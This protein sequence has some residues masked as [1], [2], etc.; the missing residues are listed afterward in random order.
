[1]TEPNLEP[2]VE[3]EDTE[4]EP[5]GYIVVAVKFED[6]LHGTYRIEWPH[7]AVPETEALHYEVFA[8]WEYDCETIFFWGQKSD[9]QRPGEWVDPAWVKIPSKA[10]FMVSWKYYSREQHEAELAV[11]REQAEKARNKAFQERRRG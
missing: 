10:Y 3:A 8:N 1:M 2:E 5:R 4:E 6:T 11:V 7:H 9:P